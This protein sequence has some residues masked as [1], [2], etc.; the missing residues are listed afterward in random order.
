[1]DPRRQAFVQNYWDGSL[2]G[3]QAGRFLQLLSVCRSLT[4]V[5]QHLDIGSP[6]DIADLPEVSHTAGQV[7]QPT[8]QRSIRRPVRS[9]SRTDRGQSGGRSGQSTDRSKVSH[10]GC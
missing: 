8:C 6:A 2:D 9:V 7:S 5:C 10:M 1:M 3:R 4:D